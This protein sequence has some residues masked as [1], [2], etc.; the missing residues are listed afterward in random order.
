[1]CRQWTA[2]SKRTGLQ[3]RAVASKNSLTSKCRVHG[4]AR[5]GPKTQAGRERIAAANTIHGQET[6]SMRIERRLGLKRLADLE[7]LA[8]ALGLITGPKTRGPK[9]R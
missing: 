4:G 9:P 8:R 2:K 6:R 5:T 7:D 1:M 3:C